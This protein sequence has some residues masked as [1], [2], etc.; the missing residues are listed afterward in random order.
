MRMGTWKFKSLLGQVHLLQQPELARYKID[1]VGV[2]EFRWK[3]GGSVSEG[4]YFV[5]GIRNENHQLGTRHL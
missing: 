5:Y 3:K 4:L 1:L 2:Q